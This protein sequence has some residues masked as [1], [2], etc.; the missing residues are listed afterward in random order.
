MTIL[1]YDVVIALQ[2]TKELQQ[3]AS[4]GGR[5]FVFDVKVVYITNSRH[6]R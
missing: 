4:K 6:Q 2:E 3:T 5:L 1:D